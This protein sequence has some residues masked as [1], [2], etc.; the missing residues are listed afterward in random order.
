MGKGYYMDYMLI[1]FKNYERGISKTNNVD[2]FNQN[3]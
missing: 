1:D 2:F 3:Y